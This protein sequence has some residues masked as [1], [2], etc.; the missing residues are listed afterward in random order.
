M[1]LISRKGAQRKEGNVF[2]IETGRMK[3]ELT[4]DEPYSSNS[5][6]I[7]RWLERIPRSVVQNATR[8]AELWAARRRSNGSRVQSSRRA[9]R[10]RDVHRNVVNRESHVIHHGVREL[11]VANGEPTDLCEKLDLQKGNRRDTPR[12]I[13]IDP[14]KFSKPSRAQDEPDQKVGVEKKC[15]R[16]VRRRETRLLSAPRHSQDHRSAFSALGTRRSRLY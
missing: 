7:R 3:P 4:D 6:G 2:G 11:R 13:P 10:T 12:A 14:R 5:A 8:R 1:T 16:A 9:C 15:H